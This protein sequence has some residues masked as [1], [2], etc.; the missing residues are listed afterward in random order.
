MGSETPR[1]NLHGS[2]TQTQFRARCL[3]AVPGSRDTRPNFPI[4]PRQE[5]PYSWESCAFRD[6]RDDASPTET[7]FEDLR[8]LVH[9]QVIN[10]V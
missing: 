5:I 1:G 4:T 8:R 3:R 2:V 7:Q 10:R 6:D 9:F